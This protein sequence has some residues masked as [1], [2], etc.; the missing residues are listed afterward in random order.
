MYGTIGHMKAKPG[1][2]S[3]IIALDKDMINRRKPKGFVGEYVYRMDSDPDEFILVVLFDSKENYIA[4]A[5]DP[6]QDKEFRKLRELMAADPHWHD[7]EVVHS[8]TSERPS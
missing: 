6:E 3:E 4:N 2:L 1:K 5:Q 8:F 7:G